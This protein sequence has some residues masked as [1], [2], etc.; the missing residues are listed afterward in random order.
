MSVMFTLQLGLATEWDCMY[1]E[2]N[3]STE[4]LLWE[5]RAGGT[6]HEA[7]LPCD[8]VGDSA[9]M[10]SSCRGNGSSCT[11]KFA[12]VLLHIRE[13]VILKRTRHDQA[14]LTVCGGRLLMSRAA[15]CNSCQCCGKGASP[16]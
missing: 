4:S 1:A 16:L 12:F 7:M 14:V 5:D 15:Q 9:G 11:T 8:I 6:C 2:L 13:D 10:V 3:H